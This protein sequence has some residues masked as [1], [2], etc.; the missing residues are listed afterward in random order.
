MLLPHQSE[1]L[2][3]AAVGCLT[4]LRLAQTLSGKCVM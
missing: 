2:L 3:N 4:T 1:V